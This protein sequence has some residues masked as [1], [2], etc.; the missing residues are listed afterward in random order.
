MTAAT[1]GTDGLRRRDRGRH[2]RGQISILGHRRGRHRR[3]RIS[4]LGVV[5]DPLV[6]DATSIVE[7]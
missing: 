3:G 4:I 7:I 2:R 6:E 5:E 1:P